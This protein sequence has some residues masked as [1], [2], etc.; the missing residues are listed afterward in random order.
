MRASRARAP[1]TLRGREDVLRRVDAAL[2]GAG[3]RAVEGRAAERG[4][5]PLTFPR[6]AVE[7]ALPPAARA[8]S[9]DRPDPRTTGASPR[10]TALQLPSNAVSA[11]S[12]ASQTSVASLSMK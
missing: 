1:S 10:F 4:P 5:C 6:A 2:A 11:P 9:G 7:E 8:A 3:T 12:A